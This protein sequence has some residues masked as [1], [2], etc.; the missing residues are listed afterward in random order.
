MEYLND[1]IQNFNYSFNDKKNI[2]PKITIEHLKRSKLRTSAE[3]M[4]IFINHFALYVLD[5]ILIVED[6]SFMLYERLVQISD[7]LM[8][9]E[10]TRDELVLL[11]TLISEHHEMYL[12]LFKDT[13]KPKMHNM[14][15]YKESI[16]H[17]G[18]LRRFWCMRLEAKHREASQYMHGVC[19]RKNVALTVAIK[20][21]LKMSN[22]YLLNQD[23]KSRLFIGTGAED[24]LSNQTMYEQYKYVLE[25]DM[26]DDS[27]FIANTVTNY[28][29][30]YSCE[31]VIQI[32]N[33]NDDS[34]LY[35]IQVIFEYNK[36]IYLIC[37]IYDAELKH[38]MF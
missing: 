6:E 17:F 18:P 25:D 34:F 15:H 31:D 33:V 1:K 8:R 2:P 28:N 23:P 32:I 11:D 7:M 9:F 38:N 26:C 27:V 22:R 29:K 36:K 14:V 21:Q 4:L 3:Q 20:D 30:R 37:K 12:E 13:L 10:I 19:S 24:F 16:A 5:K 35:G